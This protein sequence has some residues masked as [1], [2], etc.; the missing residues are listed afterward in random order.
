MGWSKLNHIR[1]HWFFLCTGKGVSICMYMYKTISIYNIISTSSSMSRLQKPG[2]VI[3]EQSVGD[4]RLNKTIL[5]AIML[6]VQ[7]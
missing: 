3:I 7:F 4:T 5:A 2:K 1:S 6:R